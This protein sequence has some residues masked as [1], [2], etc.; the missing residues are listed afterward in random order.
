MTRVW[1]VLL[2]VAWFLGP[3]A[4]KEEPRRPN[5]VV[6][7]GDDMGYA[8]IGVHGCRDIPTPH[9]DSLAK[10]GVRCTNGYVSGPY[11]SPT[12]AGLL[13]GRYQQ[14]FGHEFNPGPAPQGDIGLPLTEKTLADRLKAAGYST[15]MVGKWHLGNA[16]KFNPVNR[17]FQEYFGFLGGANTYFPNKGPRAGNIVRGLDTVDEKEYLTDAFAREAVAFIDRHKKD[18]FFLYLTFNAV[19]TPM[20][21]SDKYL[22]RF[23]KISDDRRRHYAAMMSAMD[24]AIGQVLGKLRD[25]GLE[26]DTL[27]LFVSDNGGPPVNGSNN[28][29]LRGNKAQT[30]EGGI[31]VPFLAQWKGKLP[32]GT[33]YDSPVIQLDFAPTA[34][35]AAGVAAPADAKFDGVNLLPHW[36]GENKSA[37]HERLYWRFGR[38]M[39]L[40]QGQ[41]KL[42]R[43]QGDETPHV[44]DLL[45]DVGEQKDLAEAK[46]EL[47]QS[48]QSA[49]DEWNKTLEAPRWGAP[50]RPAKR[51]ARAAQRRKTVN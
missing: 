36:T 47:L 28:G 21:A 42:V 26:N 9:L 31:R 38:Q 24:D 12:R 50:N 40:R 1:L 29:V 30:W 7:V 25:S 43:A 49:W 3:V 45:A 44:Y 14:R 2:S 5:I 51:G 32:A 17:G 16:P 15:G 23:P 41:Y 11:C 33:T 37:P 13:T 4:A 48:L 27:L 19:H 39:A 6:I 20:E 34:L 22:D 18:P 8:D 10:N 35:A 46:P